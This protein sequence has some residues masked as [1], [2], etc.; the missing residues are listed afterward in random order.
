MITQGLLPLLGICFWREGE[1][2]QENILATKTGPLQ[3]LDLEANELKVS[4]SIQN[5]IEFT[6]PQGPDAMSFSVWDELGNVLWHVNMGHRPL[7]KIQ[8]GIVPPPDVKDHRMSPKQVMPAASKPK[9]L[10]PGDKI[11]L[12]YEYPKDLLLMTPS[13]DSLTWEIEIPEV[14]EESQ[15]TKTEL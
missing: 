1:E 10:N 8:Y 9:V 14:G 7:T 12:L 11:I 15:G 2:E 4:H 13:S 6:F 5:K 3:S